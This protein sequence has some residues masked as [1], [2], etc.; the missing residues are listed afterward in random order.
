MAT[1]PF[2]DKTLFAL[3]LRTA[4]RHGSP[5]GWTKPLIPQGLKP[6]D[7]QRVHA[8]T[9]GFT[10][11]ELAISITVIVLLVTGTVVLA[12]IAADTSRQSETI[13]KM[14]IMKRA[15]LGDARVV[16][17]EART[18]F[19]Y[20]GDVGS[21]PSQ[22]QDLWVKPSG[23]P[24]Y[25]FNT[26]SKT[27][28]GWAGP[29]LQVGPVEFASNL[30]QDG[31]GNP[32]TYSTQSGT[33]SVTGQQYV[34]R[35]ISSG[36]DGI[37]GTADDIIT[38]IYSTEMYSTVTS[39]VRDASGNPVTGV[40][41]NAN[42]PRN[43]T[44]LTNVST[45]T[46][47][48]GAFTFTNVPMGTRSVTFVPLLAYNDGSAVTTGGA[49]N[50][51]QFQMLSFTCGNVT[52]FQATYDAS[53]V[54]GTGGPAYYT[55][56]KIGGATVFNSTVGPRAASGQTLTFTGVN[57]NAKT[58]YGEATGTTL[59]YPIR[60]QSAFTEPA[61]LTL[62]GTSASATATQIQMSNF[63]DA[64]TTAGNSVNM[65]GVSVTVSFTFSAGPELGGG[66]ATFTL[67]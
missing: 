52:G 11:L 64:Q 36:A 8:E 44:L 56:L 61:D 13:A 24:V 39:Y 40:T 42:Y 47:S 6:S 43:G 3:Y 53:G 26:T 5:H 33:S 4:V 48:I 45:T 27:G 66:T 28:A 21:L 49:G 51:V 16:S 63:A 22:V 34:A 37:A 35:L 62:T 41:V 29:Y 25:T 17:K 55:Q 7:K 65:S 2:I 23:I 12:S 59:T 19:G 58:C 1:L 18:D 50:N 57:V 30:A 31:W 10:L 60:V 46:D 15:I 14:T 9:G 54:S 32:I 67:P 20:V 38:E